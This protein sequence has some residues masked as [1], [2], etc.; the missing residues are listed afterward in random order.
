MK[1]VMGLIL[2]VKTTFH[3]RRADSAC[4]RLPPF[5]IAGKPLPRD[6][7]PAFLGMV[8]SGIKNVGDHP[9]ELFLSHGSH[10]LRPRV[11]SCTAN[12]S[13][14]VM[15]PP[16]PDPRGTLGVYSGLLDALKS[17]CTGSAPSPVR[18]PS[19]WTNSHNDLAT[20][21]YTIARARHHVKK[22]RGRPGHSMRAARRPTATEGR[23]RHVPL[24]QMMRTARS[25]RMEIGLLRADPRA[26]P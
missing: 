15:L 1:D 12:A 19:S 2:P 10:Q 18:D 13:S 14:S 26:P 17:N 20:M 3:P 16:V 24:R 21:D 25:R 4:A 5:P 11:G 9:E 8:H 23:K 6:R 22:G 7:L